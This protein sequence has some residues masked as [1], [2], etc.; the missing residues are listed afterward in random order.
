MKIAI[1]TDHVPTIYAHSINTLK[2]AQ[3]FYKLGHEVIVLAV[4]RIYEDLNSLKIKNI[5]VFYGINK[6][7]KFKFFRDYSPYYFRELNYLGPFLCKITQIL[8][9]II[10]NLRRFFDPKKNLSEYC[11]RK[12]SNYCKNEQ[13]DLAFCRR[14]DK[15]IYYN[16]LN[17]IPTISDIHGYEYYSEL[18]HHIKH[19]LKLDKYK[20]FKGIMTI[21][22]ILKQK[23]TKLGFSEEKI[24]AM[25]NCVDLTQFNKISNNKMRIRKK[26]HLPLDKKIIMY[27]GQ[28]SSDRGIETILKAADNLSANIYSFYLIGGNNKS[29]KKWKK[30]INKYRIKSEINLLGFIEKNFIPY[31]LKAADI[32]LATYSS[33]CLTLDI[34][35]P[36][37][38]IEYMA[39]KVPIIATKIGRI[40]EICRNNECLF[41]EPDNPKDLNEK[42][43]IIIEN[44]NIRKDL[45]LHA[46]KKAQNYS[47]EKRC[48]KILELY[49]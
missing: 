48:K 17:E 41:I 22:N 39:S 44:D 6:K 13:I 2:I 42:I 3:G 10:P 21:N 34:M 12:I 45:V 30:F 25:D 4:K 33:S 47:I 37:K 28:L 14:T 5:H 49:K 36:V 26:F 32:L 46:Y 20:N 23:L 16:I 18:K 9:K 35:S 43:K 7:I 1:I 27:T 29:I 31:Y 15:A 24:V 11:E 40:T 8:I 38:I 19:L